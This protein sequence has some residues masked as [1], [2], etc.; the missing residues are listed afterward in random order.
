M[1]WQEFIAAIRFDK[2]KGIVKL[3]AYVTMQQANILGHLIR[4][5]NE[6]PMKRVT[7]GENLRQCEQYYKSWKAENEM[8]RG[9]LLLYDFLE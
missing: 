6:D 7:I 9:Y 1:M 8:G 2:P 3:S 4:A 5:P